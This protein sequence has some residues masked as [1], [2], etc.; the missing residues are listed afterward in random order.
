M[1]SMKKIL[2]HNY[3]FLFGALYY[4][5]LPLIVVRLNLLEDYPGMHHV[6]AY[7]KT[8]YLFFYLS[9]ITLLICSFYCGSLL[10]LRYLKRSQRSNT[11][12]VI[13]SG[14]DLFIISLP[15]FLYGQYVI[16]GNVN[17]LFQGYL[18]EYDLS[19]M[20]TIST[21]NTLFLF[22]FIY[23]KGKEFTGKRYVNTFFAISIIEFSMIL[24]GLGSRMYIM[25][26]CITYT[27]FLLDKRIIGLKK[28]LLW[29]GT[30]VLLFLFIGIWRL[31]EVVS[32]DFLFYIGAAEP[33]FTWISAISM[34][35]MNSLPLIAF[36]SNFI[37]SFCNFIPTILLP[38]KDEYIQPIALDFDNP[39]GA[40]NV[41]VSLL[42]NF[43]I[44]GSCLAIF[45]LGFF[46][47]FV[48]LNFKTLFGRTY[49]YCICGIIPFQLFRDEMSIVN[50]MLFY[51]FLLFPLIL[52]LIRKLFYKASLKND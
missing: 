14:K 3:L 40:T 46:L 26:P 21:L 18:V 29:V 37:S 47:T 39:L 52:L 12:D 36:P 19:F 38:N 1:Y 48:C 4:L 2:Y 50:K 24:L 13:V 32:P 27:L 25:I 6:Y 31:D 42:S 30:G 9:L 43:G 22:F 20:G 11:V 28:M 45:C 33:T 16:Y 7:F 17:N 23:S 44:L 5:L 10:P 8:D 49:Y 35:S 15:F 34:F 51:N 41:L